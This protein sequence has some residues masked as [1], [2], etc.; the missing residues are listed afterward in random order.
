MNII[1][2]LVLVLL[3]ALILLAEQKIKWIKLV[4]AVVVS[5]FLGITLGNT[6]S[7]P[8]LSSAATILSEASVL[9]AIP[10]LLFTTDL[11][12]W[13]RL[14]RSTVVSFMLVIVSVVTISALCFLYFNHQVPEASKISGMLV[15]VF[16]GGTPNLV[17]IGKALAVDEKVFILLNASDLIVG[18]LM[19]FIL[20]SFGPKFYGLF[21]RP[22][23]ANLALE[24]D[25]AKS[26][27][28]YQKE[29][30]SEKLKEMAL[31]LGLTILIVG[32]SVLGSKVFLGEL[33][34]IF[35]ILALTAL[36][37]GASFSARLRQLK[38][39]Y[40]MGQYALLIFCVSVGSLARIEDML[41][42][43]GVYLTYLS[44]TLV[45]SMLLHLLLCV[46]FKID[47]DTA[48]ITSIAGIYGPAFI[49]PFVTVLKNKEVLVSGVTCGLVGYALGTYLGIGVHYLLLYFTTV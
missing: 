45:G 49:G 41:S 46:V 23:A 32:C 8:A 37:L 42:T 2:L 19:L 16:T 11:R 28:H 39:S 47:R 36:S 9:F 18:G 12:A 17:A 26:E 29:S 24:I 30:S 34:V 13:V 48:L 3:P 35:I 22:F 7:S 5:Y 1:Y 43:S 10:L 25:E 14:A 27:Q 4:G 40:H 20:M 21:L 31:A 44:L 6:L 15:G 33:N 38:A